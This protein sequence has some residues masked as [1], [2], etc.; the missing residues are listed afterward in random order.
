MLT[1]KL[2]QAFTHSLILARIG[3][4]NCV[5]L[6]VNRFGCLEGSL[7]RV[8]NLAEQCLRKLESTKYSRGGFQERMTPR[9]AAQIL[10]TSVSAPL[11]RIQE[12]HR[13]VMLANHPDRSGSPYLACKIN[14]AKEL[15]MGRSN[16]FR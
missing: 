1:S 16:R 2:S 3:M 10:G 6:L 11:A 12:A 13:R 15:L 8:G 9:E 4:S 7:G 14:Q 5:E